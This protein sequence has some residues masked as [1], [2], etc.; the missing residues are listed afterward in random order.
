MHHFQRIMHASDTPNSK[1]ISEGG[2]PVTKNRGTLGPPRSHSSADRADR[3]NFEQRQTPAPHP[4]QS[5]PTHPHIPGV[6]GSEILW[7]TNLVD[8][9]LSTTM[10]QLQRGNRNLKFGLQ[11]LSPL[12]SFVFLRSAGVD[13][14]REEDDKL[15]RLAC[16]SLRTPTF[17]N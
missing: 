17:W 4:K 3:S 8:E 7:R 9:R 2:P 16:F 6:D 1:L 13:V 11:S 5:N 14:S 10:E 15:V 12:P